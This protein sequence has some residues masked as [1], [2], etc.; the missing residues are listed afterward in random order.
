MFIVASVIDYSLRVHGSQSFVATSLSFPPS[1]RHL[2][3]SSPPR[4]SRPAISSQTTRRHL[5]STPITDADRFKSTYLLFFSRRFDWNELHIFLSVAAVGLFQP[6]LAQWH[7][8]W[9]R[10]MSTSIS[11]WM[12]D[13]QGRT[14]AVNL[15]PFVDTDLNM[16]LIVCVAVVALTRR[17]NESNQTK[18]ISTDTECH[19]STVIEHG[20]EAALSRCSLCW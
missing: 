2:S 17:W 18:R 14:G 9:S 16:R 5:F 13:H 1:G 7:V 4:S 20:F 3:N 11:T 19:P 15:C 12:G 10:G 8:H 6:R